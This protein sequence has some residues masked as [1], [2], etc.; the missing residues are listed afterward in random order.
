MF[1]DL[2]PA[3]AVDFLF[4]RRGQWFGNL[5][6]SL[7]RAIVGSG[8]ANAFARRAAPSASRI[9]S[10]EQRASR[11]PE[12]DRQTRKELRWLCKASR[13]PASWSASSS[14]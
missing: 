7:Q 11:T 5:P 1:P 2:P 9:R 10:A 6:P 13:G 8:T 4:L 14:R 12:T 3:A